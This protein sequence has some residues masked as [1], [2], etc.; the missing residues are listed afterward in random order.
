MVVA[1]AM[2]W[3]ELLFANWPVDPDVVSAHLP[4][5][6]AVDSHDGSAWLSVVPFTNAAVRP[7]RLPSRLGIDLPELNLQP[8]SPS[9]ARPA[10]TSSAST[11]RDSS[12]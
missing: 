6:L 12:A 7:H 10:S 8:T 5:T 1:L 3:R 11:P 2:E 4:D 9:T